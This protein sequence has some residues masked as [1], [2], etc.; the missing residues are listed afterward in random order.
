M[1]GTRQVTQ[2]LTRTILALTCHGLFATSV[3]AQPSET[4][5]DRL[6]VLPVDLITYRSLSGSG[7]VRATLADRTLEVVGSFQGLS[8]VATIAH[9]HQAPMARR[10]PS[11]FAL[12]V[13]QATDGRISG[14]VALDETQIE[15]LR[16]GELY[17][18]IHTQTNAGGE[19]RGWLLP[20][21]PRTGERVDPTPATFSSAQARRGEHAYQNV[22]ASCHQMDLSGAFEAPEL[23]GSS[24]A[25]LW[26]GRPARELFQ[27]IRAA[28]PPAGRKPHDDTLLDIVA[29]IL[30]KNGM[31]SGDAPFAPA[32]EGIVSRETRARP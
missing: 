14:T 22:C 4:F 29:F 8:S 27:Y 23:A 21:E 31:T 26:G 25:S 7:E 16:D 10:G 19:I 17:V 15:A 2:A 1:N 13:T 9:I 5:G 12:E 32:D 20:T 24:F 11:L 6:S 30:R 28:M 18:Q 3:G